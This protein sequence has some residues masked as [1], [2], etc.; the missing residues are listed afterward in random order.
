MPY[1]ITV[2]ALVVIGVGF[3]LFNQKEDLAT[4][5]ANTTPAEIVS[6][7][8][9]SSTTSPSLPTD[10]PVATPT[11]TP[12]EPAA[13]APSG[14]QPT[15][16]V[17]PQTPAPTPVPSSTYTDGTYYATKSYRTPDGTYEMTVGLTVKGDTVTNSTVTYDSEGTK[18]S[19]SKRFNGGYQNQVIGKDLGSINLSR[20]SGSSLTTAAF[21]NA[22]SSIKSQAS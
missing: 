20:V 5:T 22:L 19:Y 21:N 2:L 16:P 15:T 13:P 18:S 12:S 10:T 7:N 8:E 3:T 6:I 17:P 11:Q 1:F 4:T 9:T 14:A